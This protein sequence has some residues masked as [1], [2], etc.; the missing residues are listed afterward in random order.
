M[1]LFDFLMLNQLCIIGI[2][3]FEKGGWI[4][5]ADILFRI[6][7]SALSDQ[8]DLSFF[9]PAFLLLG[10]SCTF[11]IKWPG[12]CFSFYSP[13]HLCKMEKTMERFHQCDCHI[14]ILLQPHSLFQSLGFFWYNFSCMCLLPQKQRKHVPPPWVPQLDMLTAYLESYISGFFFFYRWVLNTRF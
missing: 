13:E 3:L 2:N 14:I 9:Y 1:T 12:E 5:F 8:L 11:P 10:S 4:P 7:V 6:F